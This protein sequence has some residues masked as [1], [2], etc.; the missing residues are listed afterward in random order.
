MQYM[1]HLLSSF[2]IFSIDF[3]H[4]NVV[5]SSMKLEAA[6]GPLCVLGDV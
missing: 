4:F 1:K 6:N 3:E 5:G 2:L